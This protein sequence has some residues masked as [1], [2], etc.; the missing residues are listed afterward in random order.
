VH[1]A[2]NPVVIARGGYQT[3]LIDATLNYLH[4]VI[5]R[6]HDSDYLKGTLEELCERFRQKRLGI[7]LVGVSRAT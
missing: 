4:K 1:C 6:A 3:T 7:N 5:T 2:C